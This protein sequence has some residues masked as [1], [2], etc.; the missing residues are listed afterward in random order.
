MRPTLNCVVTI[1]A[2]LRRITGEPVRAREVFGR[3][4]GVQTRCSGAP[5]DSF[6]SGLLSKLLSN[7]QKQQRRPS[8]I[9]ASC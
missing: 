8:R 5:C 3:M 4:V 2:A 7:R 1:V 9:G 6:T